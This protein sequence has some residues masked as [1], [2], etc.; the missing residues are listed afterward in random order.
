MKHLLTAAL[1]LGAL[2]LCL[3]VHA[4]ST[5]N[6]GRVQTGTLPASAFVPTST[7]KFPVE[8]S[9]GWAYTGT[10]AAGT[11]L[12]VSFSGS[13]FTLSIDNLAG[14]VTGPPGSNT[15]VAVQGLPWNTG[16]PT[17]N[18]IVYWDGSKYNFEAA[19]S[20]SGTVNS[21]TA[22]QLAYYASSGTAVSGETLFQAVNM[23]A[24]TGDITTPGGSLATTLATV[25]SSPGTTGDAT[26][27]SQITTNGKGL[28]T[29]NS[30]VLITGTTPGG[31]AGGSLAG[32]YPNPTI[33]NSGVTAATYGDAT[34]VGQFTVGADGRITSASNVA[35]TGG[36][37][38]NPTVTATFGSGAPYALTQ[39]YADTGI[40]PT[41]ALTSGNTYLLEG[42]VAVT[43]ATQGDSL[44]AFLYDSTA[45]YMVPW[46]EQRVVS[47]TATGGG[48]ASSYQSQIALSVL[49]TAPGNDVIK[50]YA[51]NAS[52]ARGTVLPAFTRIKVEQV[53]GSSSQTQQTNTFPSAVTPVSHYDFSTLSGSSGSNISSISDTGSA[54]LTLSAG[55][56]PPTLAVK[57]YNGLNM[58]TF[59]SGVTNGMT[60]SGLPTNSS[61]FDMFMVIELPTVS[62]TRSLATNGTTSNGYGFSSTATGSV[63]AVFD[64]TSFGTTS[65][66]SPSNGYILLELQRS[67]S[68]VTFYINGASAGTSSASFTAPTGNLQVGGAAGMNV[69]EFILYSSALSTANQSAVTGYLQSKWGL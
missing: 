52:S 42:L 7:G 24:L 69:A 67:G 21:G 19:P 50:L 48:G 3:P 54:A 8:T 31:S 1:L 9:T 55:A 61:A 38:G 62:T 59:A 64:S 26:H 58:A 28:V 35:I 36:G 34:H 23:P 57:S 51:A 15:V 5:I 39:A 29:A 20:G 22:N 17:T 37:G 44:R 32:T 14:D 53:S 2:F 25:N 4:Q 68:T 46:S 13:T 33:A 43:D 18:Y 60:T 49:Y 47:A 56:T 27:T 41:A 45:G 65:P 11:G 16:T 10:I 12:A 63:T 6:G 66:S 30:S 40:A